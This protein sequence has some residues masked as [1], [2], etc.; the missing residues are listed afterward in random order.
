MVDSTDIE[1]KLPKM[2]DNGDRSSGQTTEL[3]DGPKNYVSPSVQD[4][5]KDEQRP[6]RMPSPPMSEASNPPST[7][8]QTGIPILSNEFIAHLT[9]RITKE[10]EF[11]PIVCKACKATN[12]TC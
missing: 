2:S 3:Q 5:Y 7:E 8:Q 9:Q 4:E 6:A 11:G 10:C 12:V 1:L